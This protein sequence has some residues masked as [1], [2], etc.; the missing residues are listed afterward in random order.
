[1]R[2]V[3]LEFCGINSFSEP[4]KIDFEKLSE[5]GI[6]G[7][8]GDTG[9]G[10]STI[11]DCIV[12]SLYGSTE[13][14]RAGRSLAAIVNDKCN[15]AY[16]L[17]EFS[18]FFEG[19]R[20]T[21]RVEHTLKR[22]KSVLSHNAKV[23]ERIDGKLIAVCDGAD[24]CCAYMQRVIGMTQ[25][26]FEKC[27]AL[28]QGEF[29][30]FIKCA[31]PERL[32][33]IS[34]LFDLEAYGEK[35]Y[36]RVKKRYE[37][38]NLVTVGFASRLL[39]YADVTEES[40]RK[41]EEDYTSLSGRSAELKAALTSA[42]TEEETLR[43]LAEKRRESEKIAARLQ[44]LEAQKGAFETLERELSRLAAAAEAGR[45]YEE[46]RA[47]RA[48]SEQAERDYA[49]VTQALERAERTY[50]SL[51]G[52][53]EE[54]T[55]AA[56]ETLMEQRAAAQSAAQLSAHVAAI[57]RRLSEIGKSTREGR[58]AY[59]NFDYEAE[60]ASLESKKLSLGAADFAAYLDEA[61]KDALF[62]KEY[63]VFASELRALCAH[64]PE[65]E[66]EIE[67]L[68]RKYSA[69]ASGGEADFGV[70]RERFEAAKS[71]RE[72]LD[73]ALGALEKRKGGH[74]EFCARLSQYASESAQLREE[75]AEC[76]D[77]LS[78]LP[79]LGET[80]K[81][82]E[83]KRKE[84]RDMSERRRAALEEYNALRRQEAA[85]AEKKRAAADALEAG[86]ARY[87]AALDA[88]GFASAEEARA[89]AGRYGSAEEAKRKLDA[90]KADLAAA[91]SRRDE[92]AAIDCARATEEALRA[93]EETR[94]RCE[95]EEREAEK[96]L[97]VLGQERTRL[98][99]LLTQKRELEEQHAQAK[100][101]SELLERLKKLLEGNKFVEFL[102][103]EY[104]AT[105]AVNASARLLSLTGGRYFLRYEGGFFVGDNFNGGE[106]RAIV[107]LSGGE[108][109]LVS[110]S[111]AL[112]LGTEISRKSLRPIEF[113]FLD[114]GFGT[115][116]S[117]LVDLVTDSLEKLREE[118]FTIGIISHVEELKYRID[119]KLTV[120]KATERRG[121]QIL[122]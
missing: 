66:G 62:R 34:R 35:L 55:D 10:K 52:W 89:L 106:L 69:L 16:T 15:S 73:R 3:Y 32:K 13:R 11:L 40:F 122:S 7:I 54:E 109:F 118:N 57:D 97:A 117:K 99:N 36:D 5:Y 56:I 47:L 2:P 101:K 85:C 50:D 92:L 114:E 102:A 8:F 75:R 33:L 93:A 120:V 96:S 39:A 108:T 64:Y 107:T 44:T 87:R 58:L 12:F 20:R 80:E 48:A 90:F 46:G 67:P 27:I 38:A 78:R 83:A 103:E 112:A 72:A 61:G 6:F 68:I 76:V 95:S 111:L 81:L 43:S 45:R 65:A 91:I 28:P 49:A 88:G 17:F 70:L 105:V 116:D 26:D 41:A 60:R 74:E 37:S 59:E 24:K 9:S 82:L 119:R 18:V 25:D 29:A 115:L 31:R 113:F 71:A 51:A 86:R 53:N 77:K 1:M 14:S 63:A 121:S 19:K 42:R 104:L 98:K 22:G 21:Y 100:Q 30:Q 79:D 94:K 110:L 23:Y 4:A 84:K